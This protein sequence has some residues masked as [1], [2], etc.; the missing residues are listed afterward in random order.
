MKLSEVHI[1]YEGLKERTMLQTMS[2]LKKWASEIPDEAFEKRSSS[3]VHQFERDKIYLS[4]LAE[5]A[6]DYQ[7]IQLVKQMQ[8]DNDITKGKVALPNLA[9]EAARGILS[10]I[11]DQTLYPAWT[12]F[13]TYYGSIILTAKKGGK[14]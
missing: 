8:G 14:A 2:H 4:S 5:I 13:S 12:S 1:A 10:A 11:K 9:P 7:V 6:P 3:S